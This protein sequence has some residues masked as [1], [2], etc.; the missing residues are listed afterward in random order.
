MKFEGRLSKINSLGLVH[1][2]L[3][4][5]I[6]DLNFSYLLLHHVWLPASTFHGMSSSQSCTHYIYILGSRKKRVCL[7]LL[8][9]SSQMSH[10]TFQLISQYPNHNNIT[11]FSYKEKQKIKFVIHTHYL[12]CLFC[13]NFCRKSSLIC[14]IVLLIL[15]IQKVKQFPGGHTDAKCYKCGHRYVPRISKYLMHLRNVSSLAQGCLFLT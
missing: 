3:H 10:T 14:F 9:P 5:T 7:L 15:P 2:Q 12:G 1:Q 11:I 4:K 6:R 13:N 8:K